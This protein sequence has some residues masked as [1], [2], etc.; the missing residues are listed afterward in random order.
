M[1][2]ARNDFKFSFGKNPA[3][4]AFGVV[5]SAL[6]ADFEPQARRYTGHC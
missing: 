5:G 1:P 3:V 2:L 6:R 4:S